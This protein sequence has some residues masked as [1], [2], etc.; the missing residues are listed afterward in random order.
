MKGWWGKVGKE[1]KGNGEKGK[2]VNTKKKEGDTGR[3]W[4]VR[5][6][7]RG[8]GVGGEDKHHE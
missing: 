7:R 6:K 5:K 2:L 8:D 4:S 1:K 3:R